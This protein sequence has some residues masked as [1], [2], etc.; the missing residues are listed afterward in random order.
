MNRIA[1]LL[2]FG[3][4]NPALMVVAVTT[5]GLS[6]ILFGI[7]RVGLP[8]WSL[9]IVVVVFVYVFAV[10]HRPIIGV[11]AVVAVFFTPIKLSIGVSLLQSVGAGT[12]AIL[13]LWFFYHKRKIVVGSFMLPLFL[14]GP[15]MLLSLWYTHDATATLMYVRR[16][17]FNMMFV[18]LLLNLVTQFE[19]FKK[20]LWAIML[21]ASVN[22]IVAMVEFSR[23]TEHHYRSVGL[24]ENPNNFGQLATLA[25]PLALYQYLYGKGWVRWVGL[26]L[27]GILVGGIVVSVSRGALVSLI[28][29]F[30]VVMFLERRRLIPLLLIL[31]LAVSAIPL[32]PDFFVERVGNLTV[33]VK[34]SLLV[35]NQTGLTSRGH[36]NTAGLRIWTAHPVMGVGVGNFGFYYNQRQFIGGMTAKQTVVAHN[37]YVQTLAEMGTIGAVLLLWMLVN[38]GRSLIQ[39]RRAT[40]RNG[41]RWTYFGAIE[42]MTLSILIA[43]ASTGSVMGN[44]LWMFLGLT[45]IASRV[46]QSKSE[47]SIDGNSAYSGVF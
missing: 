10:L 32:L 6:A 9:L 29:V 3:G 8:I 24:M 25:F 18:F 42:M 30:G 12:A 35:G 39:A 11:Y 36:L 14:L 41:E 46:A 34:N 31:G 40:D 2:G 20:V 38:S 44:D 7:L 16:W 4:V 22:S 5:V 47:E 28:I 15:L 27:G 33:D 26:T 45:M 1:G 37:I 19:M 21:M 17:A 23:S 13:L 43:T